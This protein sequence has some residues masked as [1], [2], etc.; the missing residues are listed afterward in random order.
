MSAPARIPYTLEHIFSFTALLEKMPEVIGQL[1]EGMLINFYVTGGDIVGPK[2]NGKVRPVG[3]DWF[4]LRTD[5][6]AIPD[7]RI[8]FETSDGALIYVTYSGVM[9]LGADG[10]Q[11]FLNQQLPATIP[12]RV[13]PRFHTAS[14]AYQWL[15]RLQ[16][17]GI[18]QTDL[19][20][21]VINYDVYSV[22]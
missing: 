22:L 7:V 1:P 4:T 2:L 19:E 10:Y 15:N 6:V 12:L 14:P 17:I 16:C 13:T 3:G 11:K 8:T 9:D 18:G 20:R 5:G 21:L